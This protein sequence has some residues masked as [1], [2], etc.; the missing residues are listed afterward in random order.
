M[1]TALGYTAN[2]ANLICR[3]VQGDKDNDAVDV[4]RCVVSIRLCCCLDVIGNRQKA[5]GRRSVCPR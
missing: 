5:H 3:R 2:F 1:K 4:A